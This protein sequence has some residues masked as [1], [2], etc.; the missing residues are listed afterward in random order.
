MGTMTG[1]MYVWGLSNFIMNNA[2]WF[3]KQ[4]KEISQVIALLNHHYKLERKLGQN[5][6]SS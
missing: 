3:Q 4:Y 1:R 6:N 5:K 2:L